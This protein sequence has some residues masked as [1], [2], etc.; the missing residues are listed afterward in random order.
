M[1]LF[2]RIKTHMHAI[3]H[4]TVLHRAPSFHHSPKFSTYPSQIF[5]TIST[6]NQNSFVL[7]TV[8]AQSKRQSFYSSIK[9]T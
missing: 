8:Q 7:I 5:F 4:V 2:L 1:H 3:S 9:I 6:L